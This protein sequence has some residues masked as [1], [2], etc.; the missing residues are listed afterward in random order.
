M[1]GLKLVLAILFVFLALAF[2]FP[3]IDD[4]TSPL[5]DHK[6][7]SFGAWCFIAFL[8]IVQV[9]IAIGAFAPQLLGGGS[10]G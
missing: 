9:N 3:M 4:V 2:L 10:D 7:L 5:C 8:A 6:A 1:R